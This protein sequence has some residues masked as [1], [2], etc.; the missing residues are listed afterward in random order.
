MVLARIEEVWLVTSLTQFEGIVVC[1]SGL[2][3]SCTRKSEKR[4]R[5][6]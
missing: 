4:S 2:R 1:Y 3:R 5:E 6:Q